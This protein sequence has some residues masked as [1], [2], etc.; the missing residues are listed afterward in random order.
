MLGVVIP[1]W[2]TEVEALW[3]STQR[4]VSSIRTE[5]PA[6]LY[7]VPNRLHRMTEEPLREHL[8]QVS[9]SPVVVLPWDGARSVAASWNQGL[10]MAARDG[11]DRFLIMANDCYWED[12][13]IDLL[14][15]YG[16]SPESVG[17]S[18]WSGSAV[19]RSNPEPV[20]GCDF[21]GFMIRSSTLDRVGW[22]DERFRPA[23]FE[24]NDYAT[25]VVLSGGT[26]RA[27]PTA[28]FEHA[29]SLTIRSDAEA[30]HHVRHWFE[31]N[32][33]RYVAKWGRLPPTSEAE[34]RET[35]Y[36]TPWNDPSLTVQDWDR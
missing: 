34:C 10:R 35:C 26:C 22:F 5:S 2:L 24:D 21:T 15:A 36:S 19:L 20:E 25:R 29:G 17:V 28:R 6:R 27:L 1:V 16:E 9:Q 3:E 7:I 11:C 33:A 30:A 8:S 13:A 18:I 23:Y 31:I 12:G 32:K 14:L 4:A